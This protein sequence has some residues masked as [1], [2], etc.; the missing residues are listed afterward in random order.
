MF[1][2]VSVTRLCEVCPSTA[3]M[4]FKNVV[5]N[6]ARDGKL[7]RL[8]VKMTVIISYS[9]CLSVELYLFG[10][11]HHSYWSSLLPVAVGLL[12]IN[13]QAATTTTLIVRLVRDRETT[14]T[15]FLIPSTTHTFQ[16]TGRPC[17]ALK[18]SIQHSDPMLHNNGLLSVER[19][20]PA[21]SW[22]SYWL[23]YLRG[24]WEAGNINDI[25]IYLLILPCYNSNLLK[26]YQSL[27]FIAEL[28]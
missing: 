19:C 7:R 26:L 2:S 21:L 18:L 9:W 1:D 12:N 3:V 10:W 8:K 22:Q 20:N 13:R 25:G 17:L 16:P 15:I 4:E 28:G 6:A 24:A 27:L 5:F 11:F 14:P 23:S